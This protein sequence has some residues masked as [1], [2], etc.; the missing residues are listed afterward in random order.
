MSRSAMLRL[1][2]FHAEANIAD[3]C[4]I[5]TQRRRDAEKYMGP[6]RGAETQRRTGLTHAIFSRRGAEA[7][8]ADARYFFAQRRRDAEKYIGPCRGA[9]T[10]GGLTHAM[11]SR[12]GAET[13][14][15]PADR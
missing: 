1:F 15:L 12:R 5:F 3:A 13:Q 9:E 10:N 6:H 2:C 7:N 8:G 14:S 11:Y 4:N